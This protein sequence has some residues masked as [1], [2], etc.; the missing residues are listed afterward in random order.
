AT[1]ID[2]REYFSL[3]RDAQLRAQN[4]AHRTRITQ[5]I[6]IKGAPKPKDKKDAETEQ[7]EVSDDTPHT[8]SKGASN[9][10]IYYLDLY[11]RGINPA[12]HRCGDCGTTELQLGD[13]Q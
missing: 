1:Y 3:E 11:L 4:A 9:R 13:N 2:G 6:L 5:K 7:S 8:L 10:T 12:D